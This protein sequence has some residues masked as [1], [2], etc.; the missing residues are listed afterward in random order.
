MRVTA[1]VAGPLSAAML[2]G[3]FGWDTHRVRVGDS[4]EASLRHCWPPMAT[5]SRAAHGTMLGEHAGRVG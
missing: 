4:I 2:P 5:R 3:D 1:D